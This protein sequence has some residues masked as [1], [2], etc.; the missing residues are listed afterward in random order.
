MHT[1]KL[2]GEHSSSNSQSLKA[3]LQSSFPCMYN[4]RELQ[5]EKA[6]MHHLR[7]SWNSTGKSSREANEI[8]QEIHLFDKHHLCKV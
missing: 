7:F 5:P 8:T 1:M 4:Q 6:F 2:S 3:K